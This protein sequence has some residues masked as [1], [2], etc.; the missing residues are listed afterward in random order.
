MPSCRHP[1]LPTGLGSSGG[2]LPICTLARCQTPIARG[3]C[4]GLCV[5]REAGEVA[6]SLEV[7][8]QL[9]GQICA[10]GRS[11]GP[12]GALRGNAPSERQLELCG[13]SPPAP[14]H[15]QKGKASNRFPPHHHGWD[16]LCCLLG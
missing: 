10:E 15:L 12:W 7:P 8:Q 13:G 3:P 14:E 4:R 11:R 16:H 5:Y 6:H 1:S 2:W 9:Q